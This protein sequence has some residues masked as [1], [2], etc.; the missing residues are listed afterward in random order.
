MPKQPQPSRV[1]RQPQ[2][3]CIACGDVAGKRTLVRVVRTPDGTVELDSTGKKS[4]RGA[5]VHSSVDCVQ[6]VVKTGGLSRALNASVGT[7]V[8]DQLLARA[9]ADDSDQ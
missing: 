6:K 5:Y 4:G 9:V 1:R 7:E 3:T 2:R 8:T